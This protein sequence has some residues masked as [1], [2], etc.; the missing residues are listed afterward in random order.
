MFLEK[1]GCDKSDETLIK[2]LPVLAKKP[3]QKKHT[4]VKRYIGVKK[5]YPSLL[6]PV[7][8]HLLGALFHATTF[9]GGT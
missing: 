4:E 2:L 6:A 3:L 1:R 5:R 9:G 7:R 8:A